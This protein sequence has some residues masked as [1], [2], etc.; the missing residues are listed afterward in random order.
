MFAKPSEW[1]PQDV[2]T[3]HG[4][5]RPNPADVERLEVDTGSGG[6]TLRIPGD[7]GAEIEADTGSGRIDV[8]V[9]IDERTRRR[10]YLRGTIGDGPGSINVDRGSGSIRVLGR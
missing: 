7:L 1:P 3:G 8:E 9:A 5:F 10:T 4:P 6:V 2:A